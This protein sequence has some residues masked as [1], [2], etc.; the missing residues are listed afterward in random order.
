MNRRPWPETGEKLRMDCIWSASG[1][2][3]NRTRLRREAAATQ[4]ESED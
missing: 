3:H 2:E 1:E 4:K